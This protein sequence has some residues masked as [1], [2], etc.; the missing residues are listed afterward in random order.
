MKKINVLLLL[1][2]IVT[3]T[4]T[5]VVN[6]LANA[7]P[8]NGM[9]T[10]AISDYYAN[11]FAPAAITFSIWGLIYAL[12]AA[13]VFYSIFT[14]L[15]GNDRSQALIAPLLLPFIISNIA[16]S[17]WIFA[18]HYQ[19]IWLTL[20]LMIIILASLISIN[21]SFRK[22]TLIRIHQF[23]VKL[24]FAVY[25]GWITIATVANVTVFLVSINWNG[26]NIPDYIWMDIVVIIAAIIGFW[27]TWY[28]H[29]VAY[30]LVHLWAYLGIATKHMSE[31]GYNGEYISVI[32]SV[33]VAM[34]IVFSSIFIQLQYSRKKKL[35]DLND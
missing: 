12:V 24:P 25:F 10:G 35:Q 26:F 33:F 28:Y 6:A 1:I 11:L 32:I 5:L 18:W 31:S 7:L 9:D 17:L 29:S 21:L 22:M 14:Y 2:S 8:I 23:I 20:I 27:A 16:N 15:K 3:F 19:I 13:F 4:L 34:L 30:G